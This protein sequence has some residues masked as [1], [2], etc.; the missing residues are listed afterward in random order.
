MVDWNIWDEEIV[1][2]LIGEADE[3]N[4]ENPGENVGSGEEYLGD[5]EEA[6]IIEDKMQSDI[7]GIYF[8]DFSNTPVFARKEE[9]DIFKRW[10]YRLK[11]LEH[12]SQKAGLFDIIAKA[13]IV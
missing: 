9:T 4:I 10:R 1:R 2:G 8:P 7:E 13:E 3:Q 12:L 5:K 11:R 6:K